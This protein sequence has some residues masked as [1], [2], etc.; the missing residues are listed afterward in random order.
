[1][2]ARRALSSAARHAWHGGRLDFRLHHGLEPR[3]PGLANRPPVHHRRVPRR[4]PSRHHRWP[5]AP[6]R[7]AVAISSATRIRRTA[8]D[9]DQLG[10]LAVTTVFVSSPARRGLS[11]KCKTYIPGV[12]LA[13]DLK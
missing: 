6:H 9:Y 5:C 3:T 4:R 8:A 7:G 12:V 11:E 2:A 13:E 10:S 1:M